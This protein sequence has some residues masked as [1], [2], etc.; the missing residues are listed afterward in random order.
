LNPKLSPAPKPSVKNNSDVRGFF[1]V[2][3][4]GT[5]SESGKY[6]AELWKR[7]P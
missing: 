7:T 1:L 5:L 3:P 6:L 4:D 2:K